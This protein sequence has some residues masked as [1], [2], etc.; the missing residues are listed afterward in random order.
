MI[1]KNDVSE[2]RLFADKAGMAGRPGAYHTLHELLDVWEDSTTSATVDDAREAVERKLLDTLVEV[3][4]V[5]VATGTYGDLGHKAASD[6][7]KSELQL[8]VVRL[9]AA[10]Q[11]I[12]DIAAAEV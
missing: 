1:T 4:R 7:S 2:L 10:L 8:E 9:R 5:L 6:M 11:D 3:R 12:G